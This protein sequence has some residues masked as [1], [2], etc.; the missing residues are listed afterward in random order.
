MGW[1]TSRWFDYVILFLIMANCVVLGIENPLE[2]GEKNIFDVLEW[3]FNIS[4]TLEMVVKIT[5]LGFIGHEHCYMRNPWNVVDFIIVIISWVTSFFGNTTVYAVRAVRA[6]RAI[7]MVSVFP[8]MR[9][10]VT[11]LLDICV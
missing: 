11:A 2:K 1:V 6:L 3:I 8:R 9:K 10:L 7:R 5:A 4:F